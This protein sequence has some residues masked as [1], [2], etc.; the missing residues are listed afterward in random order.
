MAV[1]VVLLAMDSL[2][3]KR[4]AL[5]VMKRMDWSILVMF[6]G[7]LIWI[8]GFCNTHILH[9]LWRQFGLAGKQIDSLQRIAI[10]GVFTVLTSNIF[11]NV[12]LTLLV[13]DLLQPC[14]D[15]LPLVLYLAWCGTIAGNLTLFGSVSNLIVSQK[16]K[17]TLN[18]HLSYKVHLKYGFLSSLVIIS[19]GM[20]IIYTFM[21]IPGI[22]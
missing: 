16:A 22:T 20:V 6:F 18:Y 15:Q 12:T 8:R 7:Y 4:N 11:G 19:L 21:Q 10:F 17:V 1:A 14:T 13:I 3:N 5:I 2:I 9:W